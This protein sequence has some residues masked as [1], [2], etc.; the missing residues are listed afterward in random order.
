MWAPLGEGQ[1]QAH[2]WEC[3]GGSVSCFQPYQR[4]QGFLPL[5]PGAR[6][7]PGAWDSQGARDSQE[8]RDSPGAQDSQD[9]GTARDSGLEQS[10]AWDSPGLGTVRGSGQSG[11]LRTARGSGQPGAQD[12]PGSSGQPG[13]RD[14][15]GCRPQAVSGQRLQWETTV[16]GPGGFRQKWEKT[17]KEEN[18]SQTAREKISSDGKEKM[19]PR[20]YWIW[21]GGHLEQ[22]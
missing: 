8:A 13:A 15:L 12:S 16:E 6:D 2:V 10:G 20:G 5:Q 17:G 19:H 1:T 3:W 9:L 7:S 18:L 14:R 4:S 21:V 11:G 22:H